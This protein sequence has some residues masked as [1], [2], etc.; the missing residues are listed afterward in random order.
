MGSWKS[1][2]MEARL[3]GVSRKDPTSKDLLSELWR[4]HQLTGEM[5]TYALIDQFAEYPSSSYRNH[6]RSLEVPFKLAQR[7]F[8]EKADDV[9]RDG[10]VTDAG[11]TRMYG[12]ASEEVPPLAADRTDDREDDGDSQDL[13]DQL[14]V[15]VVSAPVPDFAQPPRTDDSLLEESEENAK[16]DEDGLD[17]TLAS[18]PNEAQAQENVPPYSPVLH[19]SEKPI[20]IPDLKPDPPQSRLLKGERFFF[21]GLQFPP[22]DRSG[23]IFLFGMVANELG[24]FLETVGGEAGFSGFRS[25]RLDGTEWSPVRL[26]FACRSAELIDRPGELS[27]RTQLICWEHDWS[28]CPIPVLSLSTLIRELP[29]YKRPL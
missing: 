27:D 26:A 11:R 6:W 17:A 5:P 8:G 25:H 1:A 20:L 24:F 29:N 14:E 19:D 22:A 7:Y 9:S 15:T 16:G 21:R 13:D 28:Q 12:G 23:V 3:P 2:L 10:Y 18:W 4:V